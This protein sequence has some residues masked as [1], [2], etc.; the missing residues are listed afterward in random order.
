M[1]QVTLTS[2]YAWSPV[3]GSSINGMTVFNLSDAKTNGLEGQGVYVWIDNS[4]KL[5]YASNPCEGAVIHNGAYSGPDP[6]VYILNLHGPFQAG[7]T[8]AAFSALDKDLCWNKQDVSGI[9]LW[10][11]AVSSC[12]GDWRLPNLQELHV[13]YEALGGDGTTA[14]S[15]QDFG[16]LHSPHSNSGGVIDMVNGS[17]WS[18]TEISTTP[19]YDFSFNSGSRNYNAKDTKYNFVRCVRTL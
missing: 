2:A 9:K 6:G 7:W 18:S 1:P 17:Y 5:L 12:T 11:D 8:N 13:L 4:W 19:A 14:G 10:A 16:E 3:S 15:G